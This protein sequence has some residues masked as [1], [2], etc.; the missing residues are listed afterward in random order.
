MYLYMYI[1]I[2]TSKNQ[3]LRLLSHG[4]SDFLNSNAACCKRPPTLGQK[5]GEDKDALPRKGVRH[6]MPPWLDVS[7]FA[8]PMY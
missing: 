8:W 4:K 3:I 7:L 2:Y 6:S 1:Y 5:S